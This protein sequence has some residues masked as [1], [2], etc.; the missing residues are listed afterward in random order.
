MRIVRGKRPDRDFLMLRNELLRDER[1]SE[2]ARGLLVRILS[3]PDDW[4]TDSAT[5]AEQCREGRDAIRKAMRDLEAAGYMR[6]ER[7]RVD[8]GRWVTDTYVYDQPVRPDSE[9]TGGGTSAPGAAARVS[10][11]PTDTVASSREFG[12]GSAEGRA[13]PWEVNPQVAP[14]TGFQASADQASADQASEIQALSTEDCYEDGLGNALGRDV[15]AAP[16]DDQTTE[17][18]ESWRQQDRRLFKELLGAEC[19]EVVK[20]S[21]RWRTGHFSADLLY[22]ALAKPV[23]GDT[24][25]VMRYPG[26]VLEYKDGSSQLEDWL[27][28]TGIEPCIEGHAVRRGRSA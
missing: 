18:E 25:Q 7:R 13:D 9:G 21:P 12:R 24:R 8:R 28:E 10:D 5:L 16:I 2:R 15:V 22:K 20:H 26:R 27:W 3:Y 1:I 23:E 11:T 6:R 14:E 4:D 17:P 19:A